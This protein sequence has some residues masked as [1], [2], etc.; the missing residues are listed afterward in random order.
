ILPQ[1]QS[2]SESKGLQQSTNNSFA[3]ILQSYPYQSST[4]LPSDGLKTQKNKY[5][6]QIIGVQ[7]LTNPTKREQDS[8][9]N[10]VKIFEEK[11][12]HARIN[13]DQGKAKA[14]STMLTK[15]SFSYFYKL[16]LC[17]SFAAICSVMTNHFE[18]PESKVNAVN[19]WNSLN[20]LT[21][22]SS[23]PQKTTAEHFE[24]F[25][26]ELR[27]LEYKL[28]S[29]LLIEQFL[30]MKLMT[31][32]KEVPACKLPLEHLNRSIQIAD[33][34][35]ATNIV[36]GMTPDET[37]LESRLLDFTLAATP[38]RIQAIITVKT[39]V[40]ERFHKEDD[41]SSIEHNKIYEHLILDVKSPKNNATHQEH[42]G[43]S[44]DSD[45]KLFSNTAFAGE[46]FQ[47]LVNKSFLHSISHGAST[48]WS[49]NETYSDPVLDNTNHKDRSSNIEIFSN[50]QYSKSKLFGILIDT[51][52]ANRSIV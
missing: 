28:P 36:P 9:K 50:A 34:T 7:A 25:V 13:D 21:R 1:S 18:G 35:S 45:D 8:F 27:K 6:Q 40:E 39:S 22:I 19:K 43:L 14:F 52:A 24:A 5:N 32:C 2:S 47:E 20:L 12:S 15:D 31:A 44:H 37:Y 41:G 16:P 30:H 46:I 42:D 4:T 26:S 49:T 33:S 38:K 3:N 51:G 10:K 23:D 29:D 48:I 17:N 11:C